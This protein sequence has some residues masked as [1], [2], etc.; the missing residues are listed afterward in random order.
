M[1]TPLALPAFLRPAMATTAKE[2]AGF[3]NAIDGDIHQ[4]RVT[5]NR[6]HRNDAR[7]I[8]QLCIRPSGQWLCCGQQ[9][10]LAPSD[11]IKRWGQRLL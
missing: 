5:R 8:H 9:A 2:P 10:T 7:D 1:Q 6:A 3:A 11:R 4:I